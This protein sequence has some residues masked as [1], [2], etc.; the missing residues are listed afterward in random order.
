MFKE[1]R[2]KVEKLN[3]A[4]AASK[5][6]CRLFTGKEF[7]TGLAIIIG[8][9][10]FTRR[11]A[12]FFSVKDQ[13]ADDDD[14][15]NDAWPL[16]WQVPCFEQ[17]MPFSRWKDLQRCFPEI[18]ADE[19][20]QEKD[21]WYQSFLAINKFNAIHQRYLV[22][23]LRISIDETMSAW[24]PWKAALGGLPNMLFIERKPEPLGKT[25]TIKFYFY[26]CN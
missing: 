3:N 25:L 6:K 22:D 11:G 8:A 10:K 12:D 13:V 15:D 18:F 21:P 2:E 16:W 7:L 14:D 24:K 9:E 23:S 1:C 17:Y 5:A 19:T 4:V 26:Y 20:K